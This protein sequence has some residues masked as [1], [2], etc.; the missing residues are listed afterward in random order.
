MSYNLDM[1][2]LFYNF[3]RE[4]EEFSGTSLLLSPTGL[5]K[6]DLNGAVTVLQR[7]YILFFAL[8]NTI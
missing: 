1:F 3:W 6:R 8:V 2:D 4:F 5:G 7:A